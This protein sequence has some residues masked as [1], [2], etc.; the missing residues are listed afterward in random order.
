MNLGIKGKM[1]VVVVF[2]AVILCGIMW[3]VTGSMK[4]MNADY[5][6][7]L[8]KDVVA[9]QSTLELQA[10]LY[11]LGYM[12]RGYFIN[13]TDADLNNYR[14]AAEELEEHLTL[15]M[16]SNLVADQQAWLEFQNE[17]YNYIELTESIIAAI[18]QN[19]SSEQLQTQF[20]EAGN[21]MH[22][23]EG[24]IEKAAINSNNQ[25]NA[26]SE[27]IKNEAGKTITMS[28]IVTIILILLMLILGYLLANVIARPIVAL[29]DIAQ[30]I[31]AS[32][33]LTLDINISA[34]DEVGKLAGAFR[35]MVTNVR[36]MVLQIKE[37]SVHVAG[38]AQQLTASAQQTAA[39]ANETASTMSEIAATVEQVSSNMQ[40]VSLASDSATNHANEGN[41][42]II[43]I[44]E[45][46][47][48]NVNSSAE[49]SVTIADLNKKIQEINR[50]VGLITNIADQT[51]LLALNAA[52]EAARAGDQGRGFAVV[53]EEVR[54]LAEQSAGATKEIDNL[55][56]KIQVES[57][58]AVKRMEDSTK[59]VED[60]HNVI[61]EVGQRFKEIIGSV[62]A[63]SSQVHDVAT[64]AEQIS[65][66]IQNVSAASEEQTATMEEVSASAE[67]LSKLSDE[68]NQLVARFKV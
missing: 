33:D 8:E 3:F 12:T 52:I 48:L 49:V 36:E 24:V 25:T 18:R 17:V 39:G 38:A 53:A 43:D 63:L 4:Q 41:K 23:L 68:L 15:H 59:T 26:A 19:V 61:E 6:V 32:R 20:N 10:H 56:S 65:S 34:Q 16:N 22:G 13:K 40:Q 31:T 2:C 67:S 7:L 54:M 42:G 46:M 66:G 21:V 60:L 14:Q 29:A 45:Q 44:N 57:Q 11:K 27:N 62:Q 51:N 9:T 1:I 37:K 35:E 47:R 58:D 5:N 50:I 64:A 30:K 55:V 28:Y